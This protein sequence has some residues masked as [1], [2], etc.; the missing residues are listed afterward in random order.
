MRYPRGAGPKLG[1]SLCPTGRFHEPVGAG[2]AD[3]AGDDKGADLAWVAEKAALLKAEKF[4]E[5]ATEVL[6][7]ACRSCVCKNTCVASMARE[8]ER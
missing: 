4:R 6:R 5:Q 8:E 7:G 2:T 3:L 1:R